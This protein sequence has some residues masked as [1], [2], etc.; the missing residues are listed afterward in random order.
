[1]TQIYCK[2]F[3][4]CYW[5]LQS[6]INSEASSDLEER[7]FNLNDHFTNS[8]YRNVCRSLFEKDKLFV[9]IHAHCWYPQGK[10]STFGLTLFHK[11]YLLIVAKHYSISNLCTIS[12]H[13]NLAWLFIYIF[14]RDK[15]DDDVWRFLLTGGVA[16]DNPYP[17]PAAEWLTDKSWSEIVRASNLPN[18]NGLMNRKYEEF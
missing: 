15:I 9:L 7:I 6:I 8:I 3:N 17:N 12:Y 4:V 14:F 5:F 2:L 10:V 18:L 13:L 16:L 1:M 11:T